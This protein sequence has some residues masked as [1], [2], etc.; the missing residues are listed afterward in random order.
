MI[1]LPYMFVF[2]SPQPKAFEPTK[3]MNIIGPLDT[4]RYAGRD[5]GHAHLALHNFAHIIIRAGHHM[6]AL[7]SNIFHDSSSAGISL[8][9]GP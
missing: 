2:S 9:L 5:L 3:V 1:L 4:L 6:S 7:M 8:G